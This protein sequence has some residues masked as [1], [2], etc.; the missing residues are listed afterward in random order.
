LV[1]IGLLLVLGGCTESSEK[2]AKAPLKLPEAAPPPAPVEPSTTSATP[3]DLPTAPAGAL[4]LTPENTKI[5]FYGSKTQNKGSHTGGFKQF[6]GYIDVGGGNFSAGRIAV[7]IDMNSI[8]SDNNKL[9]N[10]LKTPDFFDVRTNPRSVF[11]SQSIEPSPSGDATHKITGNLT[12]HGV[13]KP[14]AF[15][16]KITLTE[17]A[18]T[19]HSQFPIS[20]KEFEMNY[21]PER[22]NDE[23]KITVTVTAP[24]K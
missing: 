4:R 18:L 14:I 24:R 6:S 8:Y 22:V 2:V 12:M 17:D 13:T 19:L 20:R 5:E 10:H 16:A 9:T 3:A 23:V 21:Q 1:L 11:V 7:D 15:P